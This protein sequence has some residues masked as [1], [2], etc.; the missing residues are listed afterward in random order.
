TPA[1]DFNGTDTFTVSVDDGNGGTDTATVTITVNP[2]NDAPDGFVQTID[3]LEDTPTGL[4]PT[5]PT[6]VDDVSGDLR[7]EITSVPST[8]LG[9]FS[10]TAVPGGAIVPVATG[11]IITVVEFSSLTFTPVADA[12]GSVAALTYRAFDDE[13][14]ASESDAGSNGSIA[15]NVLPVNDAPVATDQLLAVEGDAAVALNPVAPTDIDNVAT[16]LTVTIDGWTPTADAALSYREDVTNT[17]IILTGAGPWTLSVAEFE[18]LSLQRNGGFVGTVA[19]DY[20]VT[21]LGTLSDSAVLTVD[22][23]DDNVAPTA[24][25][26]NDLGTAYDIGENTPLNVNVLAN[27]IDPDGDVLEVTR[28]R[29]NTGGASWVL[30]GDTLTLP[31]VGEVVIDDAGNAVVTP[32]GT[33]TGPIV[34]IEYEITDPFG[35][36]S[37]A[38]FELGVVFAEND[39]PLATP[40]TLSVAEDSGLTVVNLIGDDLGNGVDSDEEDLTADLQVVSAFIPSTSQTLTPG[41]PV[42]LVEGEIQI[43]ANGDLRFTPAADFNGTVPQINYV[44]ED[45]AGAQSL[46]TVDIAVT[47]VND[48]PTAADDTYTAD[49]DSGP[50]GGNI[51][52]DAGA[53]LDS[54][55]D[56]DTLAIASATVDVAGSPVAITLGVATDIFD[57]GGEIVGSLTLDNDGGFVFS[58]ATNFNGAVPSV[59][60]TLSDGNGGTDIAL[61]DITISPVNDAP[62]ATDN[63][64]VVN[65]GAVGGLVGNVLTQ[66]TG[67][68]LDSDVDGETVTVE[69][70]TVAGLPS[71][72]AA[73]ATVNVPTAG[74][75]TIDANGDFTFLPLNTFSG[76]VPAVTVTVTDSSAAVGGP[77]TDTAA[78]AIE[79]VDPV[80]GLQI[81]AEDTPLIFS[82]ATGI[83]FDLR[84]PLGLL[85]TALVDVTLSADHGTLAANLT[86]GVVSPDNGSSTVTLTGSWADVTAALDGL[87][88]NSVADYY[89]SDTIT[90]TVDTGVLIPLTIMTSV[91]I[92]VVARV[93]AAD[94]TVT[95]QE[96]VAVTLNVLTGAVQGG[97]STGG[98]DNFENLQTPGTLAGPTLTAIGTGANGPSN[99]T[100]TFSADGELT[101]TPDA[102]FSGTDSF[103]YT[104]T[105]PDGQGGTVSETAQVNV[106]V[107]AVDDPAVHT[108]PDTSTGPIPSTT[109]NEDTPLVFTAGTAN[110]LSVADPDSGLITTQV[111]VTFGTLSISPAGVT[112]GVI[113]SGDGSGSLTLEGTVAQINA[114][115]DGLTYQPNADVHTDAGLAETLTMNTFDDAGDVVPDA[116]SVVEIAITSAADAVDDTLALDEDNAVVFN[117]LTGLTNGLPDGATADGFS[118]PAATVTVLGTGVDGPQSGV[119]V[120]ETSGINAGQITYTPNANFFGTDTFLYTVQ[121]PDGQGGFLVETARITM[122]VASVN[123]APTASGNTA[124][125]SED[126]PVTGFVT[127]SDVDGDPLVAT[128]LT[129]PT[130]GTVVVN[131]DGTYSYT[132]NP[133]FNGNDNF[134]VEVSDGQGGTTTATVA[135]LINPVNDAPVAVV[136]APVTDEGTPVSGTITITDIDGDTPTATLTVPPASGTVTVNPDGT[137]TYTPTDDFSGTDTF[138]V[139]IDDGKAGI[140]PATVTVIVNP[141]NDAPTSS[142]DDF[143]VLEDTP[144]ALTI[145]VP[146]DVDDVAADLS[147]V[148][149]AIPAI[150]EG[151]LT[152]TPDAPVGPGPFEVANGDVLS[153]AELTSLIF[154]PAAEYEGTVSDFVYVA[155]DDEGLQ[156]APSTVTFTITPQN[157]LPVALADAV[158]VLEDAT[159][160]GNLIT[161]IVD[162][163]LLGGVDSDPEGGVLTLTG[164][165]VPI[166]GG[167]TNA[168]ALDTPT[169]IFGT[170]GAAVGTLTLSGD[171]SYSFAPVPDYDGAVPTIT[172]TV[173]DPE[174]GTADSTLTI[175]IVPVNDS[176]V[177]F[178]NTVSTDEDVAVS[179]SPTLPTDA[180][181]AVGSL[182]IT[183]GSVPLPSQGTLSYTPDG[184]GASLPVA[185]GTVLTVTEFASL[186]FI[187][188]P[189]Y[190]GAVD[191]AT[192][193]VADDEGDASASGP[194]STGSIAFT[195]VAVNDRPI[196]VD[197][198]PIAVLEDMPSSGNVLSNDTD[199][200]GDT[201]SL[202]SFTVGGVPGSFNAG[203]TATIPGVGTLT[204][205]AG[206]GYTFTPEANYAG[207][208]PSATYVLTDGQG[209]FGTAQL[210]FSP[211]TA[212]NDNPIAQNNLATTTQD[213]SVNGN[214][215]TDDE[216]GDPATVD[217]DAD[218]DALTVTGYTIDGH[219]GP[220]FLGA[221]TLIPSVGSFTMDAA[222]AWT[223]DPAAGF[224]G[225]TPLITYTIDDGNGGADNAE[226]TIEVGAVNAAPVADDDAVTTAEDTTVIGVVTATDAE[227]DPFTF[228]VDTQPTNG[229]LTFDPSG[230]WTYTPEADFVGAD[231]FIILADDGMGGTDRAT[232]SVTVTA[233][234]DTVPDNV[235]TREDTAATFNVLTGT[236]GA[237]ADTFSGPAVVN[238]VTQG[239][240][241]SVTFDGA[242]NITYTPDTGFVGTDT[243]TYSVLANGTTETETVTITVTDVNS[244]PVGTDQNVE[245]GPSQTIGGTTIATDPD[246]DALTQILGTGPVNG[247]VIVN[248]DLTWDYTPNAG[249]L[250]TDTFTVLVQ[251]GSGESTEVTVT[252]EV[253]NTPITITVSEPPQT[254]PEDTVLTGSIEIGAAANPVATLVLDATNG[255]VIITDPATGD[256]TYTPNPDYNGPD[257]FRVS[258]SDPVAGTREITVDITVTP[259]DDPVSVAVPLSALSLIDGE[260]AAIATTPLFAD[261][262]GAVFTATNLPFGF[263]IDATTGVISG[264]LPSDASQTPTVRV[265][266]TAQDTGAPVSVE[267]DLSFT[268]PAPIAV[269][270]GVQQIQPEESVVLNVA[271]LFVD[272]D[273]DTLTFT[274]TGLP[275]WLTL[276][277]TTGIATGNVPDDVQPGEG[278]SFQVTADD[279]QGGTATASVTLTAPLPV[280]DPGIITTDD[281][282]TTA[283]EPLK[284]RPTSGID[285]VDPILTNVIDGISDLSGTADLGGQ[286]GIIRD[287]VNGIADTRATSNVVGE[288]AAVLDAVNAIA[289]LSASRT[290]AEGRDELNGSWDIEGLTGYSL[291]LGSGGEGD[292]LR[293]DGVEDDRTSGDLI[294]DTYVRN[295]ILFIDINNSFDPEVQGMVA[296]YSVEMLDGSPVPSWLRIVRDG[297]VVAERPASL[298]DLELK[299]SANFED[300]S[301]V[302]RGVR[303]DGPTGEIEAVTLAAPLV[304]SGYG[305]SAGLGFNDQLRS[306]ADAPGIEYCQVGDN[307]Q[308]HASGLFEAMAK[309][310]A[311]ED[312]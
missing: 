301:V 4:N 147:V 82:V 108:A 218:G 137:Y 226:L 163:A 55:V 271:S 311:A 79:V 116:T 209:G 305:S 143:V 230:S 310:R 5:L 280:V 104:I 234:T 161:G 39:A 38:L 287:A 275:V 56:G 290:E 172:Y 77:L 26:D 200:D 160:T 156:A 300:G 273:G 210:S 120:L 276:D 168:V 165:V 103:Q 219:A 312:T 175:T 256:Y 80:P 110:E 128:L 18:A 283:F 179:V 42:T 194:Q 212:V 220:I 144:L 83:G 133:D 167:G 94:D 238:N 284:P 71:T 118:S 260:T 102:N 36:T 22:V 31:G 202:V 162:G 174:G 236:T 24:I 282:G 190:S 154:V 129:P 211:V 21:D 178:V 185:D 25:N 242:G 142:N 136:D 233:V 86:A 10:Y 262:D 58:P 206:G 101:Y 263:A 14:D 12:N 152:Y 106:T 196:G 32:N 265:T 57:A 288:D 138:T 249:F 132:P 295:R 291:R 121:T 74:T 205:G 267:I 195:I 204:I 250:G 153:I 8:T 277:H 228:S 89:G 225:R 11:Q 114:A 188:A 169:V 40:D 85:P 63:S 257:S 140:T 246:G 274:A 90:L 30:V 182:N 20:T 214:V 255:T 13:G 67:A 243:F 150:G 239:G 171:G 17:V 141:I 96:D 51:I 69:S 157:D 44:I 199:A 302:S 248:P 109:T 49:E 289:A 223:F 298:W 122:N 187:G 62:V 151:V 100:V 180:D 247:T 23:Q 272:P 286:Q 166:P 78:L 88:Y 59:T 281:P 285:Q 235:T 303:I 19:I 308:E 164:A 52:T 73:G 170:G 54:D 99:G 123:D 268:N 158:T 81:V 186:N 3:V 139:E 6:D 181:D 198:G 105:T 183:F 216:G 92:D 130:N 215:I 259:V 292:A 124:V 95:T 126:N 184:G 193:V 9:S 91:D 253:V 46:A 27:D 232:V 43:D 149:Q 97:G 237:S 224:N 131:T 7:V 251:D 117:P 33:Y 75:L 125:T 307:A 306:I 197:D 222:G 111:T 76:P 269:R 258:V 279:G 34:D 208:V 107:A 84:P 119:A 192:Y 254:T 159:V 304:V 241:G 41:V 112:A 134:V 37:T 145:T 70:F 296:R 65:S 47:S 299:I 207:V 87:I 217:S 16:E 2:Q 177:G 191:D 264:V 229:T 155:Q 1:A 53:G 50:V 135:V 48:G 189:D 231:S 113:A 60:Y 28:Y 64:Y 146:T 244:A 115:L 127:M 148:V 294:I 35:E 252:I 270:D 297:F 309:L 240:N 221:S 266:V 29:P 293:S 45:T 227:G 66:D 61:L 173:A 203:D 72:F 201:L 176:P 68:G 261:A 213:T 15:V 93:D 98:A 245:T 278:F